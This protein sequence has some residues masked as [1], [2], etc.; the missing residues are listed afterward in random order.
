[1]FPRD[2]LAFEPSEEEEL[3]GRED[4]AAEAVTSDFIASR[5]VSCIT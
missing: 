1:M 5:I 4:P 3:L 2:L